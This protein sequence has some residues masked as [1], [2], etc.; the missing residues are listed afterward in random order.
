M[1]HRINQ[2]EAREAQQADKKQGNGIYSHAMPIIILAF[3]TFVFR[4]AGDR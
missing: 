4:E 3:Q 1:R 2:P